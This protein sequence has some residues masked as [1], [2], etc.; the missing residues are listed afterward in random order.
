MRNATPPLRRAAHIWLV[1]I[2]LPLPLLAQS[3]D[4]N[5]R[6]LLQTYC[7]V[8]HNAKAATAGIAFDSLDVNAPAA[9]ASQWERVIRKLR[10]G[11]MPPPGSPRP[12][13]A[14]YVALANHLERELDRA[15]A[16]HPN[17]GRSNSVHRLNRAEYHNAVRDLLALDVDVKAL[18]PGDETAD[19]GFD[20]NADVLTFTTLHLERYLS[21]AHQLTRLA[22]GLAPAHPV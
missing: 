1:A 21:V 20:N 17:P 7:F 4:P 19:G 11:T 2:S 9:Q 22:I 14:A 13:P 16:A 10:T 8:C 6:G 5:P 12:E 18:L 15:A 3:T